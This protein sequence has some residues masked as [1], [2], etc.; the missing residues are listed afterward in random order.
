MPVENSRH[1][2]FLR[3]RQEQRVT[4]A[5]PKKQKL[6]EA[7]NALQGAWGWQGADVQ[8]TAALQASHVKFVCACACVCVRACVRACIL[9]IVTRSCRQLCRPACQQ[10]AASTEGLRGATLL[11]AASCAC[12]WVLV[13]QGGT[14]QPLWPA[15]D[16]V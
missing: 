13:V 11:L 8:Q 3:F 7:Q 9:R 6:E 15:V 5:T 14:P 2:S 1:L 12:H 4:A 10:P 16:C